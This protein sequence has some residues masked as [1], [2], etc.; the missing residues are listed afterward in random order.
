MLAQTAEFQSCRRKKKRGDEE[1]KT[2]SDPFKIVSLLFILQLATNTK[3]VK[4]FIT[5][6]FY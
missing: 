1:G 3:I 4:L 6:F 2:S 5:S